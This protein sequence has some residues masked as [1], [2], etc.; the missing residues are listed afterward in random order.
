M[1]TALGIHRITKWPLVYIFYLL[2]VLI[3]WSFATRDLN[4]D[5]LF[6]NNWKVMLTMFFG[7]FIAGSSPEGS[8][9]I[10]YPVFTLLLKIH[11][12]DAR[13]FAFAIQSIGMTA[14]SV[15]ILNKRIAVDWKYIAYIS[16]SGMPGL[17][18]GSFLLAPY[19]APS[20]AKFIFV[21]LWFGFGLVLWQIN[22]G[23]EVMRLSKLPEL[24][25]TDAA[26]LIV[27][28]FLGGLI[29]SIFGTGINI[30]SY[31]FL[32]SYYHLS[33]KV[34]TP[35]SVIIMTIETIL[36][37]MLHGWIIKDF[38]DTSREMWLSCI[39]LVIFLAPLGAFAVQRMPRKM[40]ARFLSFILVIQYFGAMLVLRPDT[41][42]LL[43]S[44][45]LIL[46][47]VYFFLKITERG[48]A[49]IHHTR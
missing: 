31:C 33:E 27:C 9:S 44:F 22:R 18:L 6:S 43:I 32:V 34:A 23:N 3:V 5:E 36:G 41:D 30:L 49:L 40:V 2:V 12:E 19:I 35:S 20:T 11:P 13:N 14:A 4:Y 29:S 28:G 7:A 25:S 21:S 45:A 10:A 47:S 37:F 24:N 48:K 17:I 16:I 38:S 15:F 42:M 8:A 1:K 26:A 39:P 46:L